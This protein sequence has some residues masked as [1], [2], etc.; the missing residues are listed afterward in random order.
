MRNQARSVASDNFS[1]SILNSL[2]ANVAVLALDGTITATNEAWNRFAREN[3]DAP[4][5]KVGVRVN[6]LDACRRAVAEGDSSAQIASDGIQ[7]VL[8]GHLPFFQFEYPCH[9]QTQPRWF[10][11]SVS[12]LLGKQGG[13][14]VTHSDITDRKLAELALQTSEFTIRS[15]LASAPQSVIAVGADEKIVFVNGRVENMFGYQRG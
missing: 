12:P 14:V 3:G 1:E 9:S 6:Y 7:S 13:A 11:M 15:L 5:T 2:P 4:L 8:D 10:L